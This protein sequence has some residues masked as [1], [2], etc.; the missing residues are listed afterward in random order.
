M[1][2]ELGQAKRWCVN[3]MVLGASFPSSENRSSV[4]LSFEGS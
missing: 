2:G 1:D 4:K 3:Y